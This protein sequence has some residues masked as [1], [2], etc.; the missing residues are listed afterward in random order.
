M[1]LIIIL[2]CLG[3]ERYLGLGDKL[4][5]FT[6]FEGCLNWWKKL[7]KSEALW[8]GWIGV[9]TSLV[10]LLL[11]VGLVYLLVSHTLFGL[12]GMIL[13]IAVLLYSLGPQDLYHQM[14]SYF[15]AGDKASKAD[16]KK[17]VKELLGAEAAKG[18]KVPYRA[19]TDMIFVQANKRLFSVLIWFIVLGPIGALLYRT[20]DL[21]NGLANKSGSKFS[22]M[23]AQANLLQE[24]LDWFPVRLM[25]IFY[26]LAGNFHAMACWLRNVLKGLKSGKN[27]TVECSLVALNADPKS[28]SK[29]NL[30]ENKDAMNLL[31]RA[32]VI[33]LVFIAVFTLGALI[34]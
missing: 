9:A 16:T 24:I 34:Y 1:K 14:K 4:K 28:D 33:M 18:E 20:T 26:A 23:S 8:K 11:V 31:D 22:A 29:A 13:A 25:G 21:F 7:I 5:R 3:L 12:G 32:T 15:A 6:W 30:Q 2:I 19:V 17:C 10:P 27:M